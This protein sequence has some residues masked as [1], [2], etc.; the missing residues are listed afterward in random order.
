MFFPTPPGRLTVTI[1]APTK[2]PLVSLDEPGDAQLAREAAITTAHNT[3]LIPF[4]I[5]FSQ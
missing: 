1:H 3:R 5:I 4:N 2:L